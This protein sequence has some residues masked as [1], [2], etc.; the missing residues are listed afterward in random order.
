M[1]TAAAWSPSLDSSVLELLS[2]K[3]F[4]PN[5]LVRGGLREESNLAGTEVGKT[6]PLPVET[7]AGSKRAANSAFDISVFGRSNEAERRNIEKRNDTVGDAIIWQTLSNSS[8]MERTCKLSWPPVPTPAPPLLPLPP[9]PPIIPIPPSL[10]DME[11]VRTRPKSPGKFAF[12]A[13]ISS[14]PISR[15]QSN[16]K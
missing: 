1:A 4:I 16:I 12:E 14:G 2:F 6:A 7:D 10:S 5:L 15:I 8:V 13:L 9:L 3:I 11:M